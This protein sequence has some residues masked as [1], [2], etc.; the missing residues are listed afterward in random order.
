MVTLRFIRLLALSMWLGSI[1]F[2]AAVVA[3]VSFSVLPTHAL[4]G[5]V[6]SGSLF[7]LHWIGVACAVVFLLAGFLLTLIVRDRSLFHLRDILLFA[8]LAITLSA[9]F[10]I[11]RKMEKLRDGM[12]VIDTVPHDD[13]RR[14]EFNRMHV[15]STRMEGSVFVCGLVLMYLVVRDQSAREYRY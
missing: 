6:V 13:P 11:E 9:H 14:V 10:G 8:M 2:F 12:G 5:K 7:T 3:P 1:F 4:A 15:W